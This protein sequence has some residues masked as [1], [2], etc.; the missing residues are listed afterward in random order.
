MS[1]TPI[2][3]LIWCV[4]IC[5]NQTQTGADILCF[6]FVGR[7]A[8]RGPPKVHSPACTTPLPKRRDQ[9]AFPWT[10]CRSLLA[11]NQPPDSPLL[12]EHC[13]YTR[14]YSQ[15]TQRTDVW[16]I[17]DQ[18]DVIYMEAH[19]EIC[20]IIFDA[21]AYVNFNSFLLVISWFPLYAR[22]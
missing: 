7:D 8:R 22:Y 16:S 10:Y 9:L 13:V 12:G 17:S 15:E 1:M 4:R 20:S 5:R 2:F 6:R 19:F 3:F 21:L 11:I 14:Y 18:V